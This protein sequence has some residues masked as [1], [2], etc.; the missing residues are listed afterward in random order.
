MRNSFYLML[1]VFL[2][3][4]IALPA[5]TEAGENGEPVVT[6][7][8]I[9]DLSGAS[10]ANFTLNGGYTFPEAHEDMFDGLSA[11]TLK[12]E[13]GAVALYEGNQKRGELGSSITISPEARANLM[14]VNQRQYHGSM[15]IQANS[16][17]SLSFYNDVYLE[18]Y[19][20]GVVPFE[21]PAGWHEEALKAQSIAARTYVATHN[22]SV[23]DTVS[24]QVY[25]G[26][27][28]TRLPGKINEVV[29][30]TAGE[31]LTYNGNLAQ[32]FYSSSNGGHTESNTGAWG[33][34]QI[35]YLQAVEDPYDPQIAWGTSFQAKQ[36]NLDQVDRFDPD[37][38]WND[39]EED[40]PALS[41]RIASYM[42]NQPTVPSQSDIKVVSVNDLGFSPERTDG[43]RV[44]NSYMSVDY[45]EKAADGYVLNSDGSIRVQT[46]ETS[47]I[48]GSAMR[49]M[50]G[51]SDMRTLL[52]DSVTAPSSV[53]TTRV[54]GENRIQTAV[55][56]SKNLYPDGFPV[57]HEKKT[58]FVST[59]AEFA[60][61]LSAG[62]LAKQEGN[63][64]ILLNSSDRLR[65]E[66]KKEIE[67][68]GAERIVILGGEQAIS[69]EVAAEMGGLQ[70]NPSVDRI[71]GENRYV[72]NQLINSE[73]ESVNG[74][75]VASGSDF[76]DAL[77][78][79]PVASINN[80]AI[81]LTSSGTLR[82]E[83]QI[84]IEQTSQL[85][86]KLLGGSSAIS[87]N[88]FNEVKG[89]NSSA[90]R[91]GG[92]N[93]YETLA[94]VL[95]EFKDDFN[96]EEL[97]VSTGRNFPD[98]LT[99]ATLSGK[100][101]A[102]L[103][104]TGST[105]HDST[106]DFTGNLEDVSQLTVLGGTAAVP[107]TITDEIEEILGARITSITLTGYGFGHGVGMSQYG[108]RER[109]NAGH[110]YNQIIA[111]Y[112]QGTQLTDLY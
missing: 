105:L 38:W 86:L 98:A 18:D 9:R 75:F 107:E 58:V 63:A 66:V 100:T 10:Q 99:A 65:T 93:R 96:Q 112:Y 21:M 34:P 47:Q 67:R 64:P 15:T 44:V 2:L 56:V 70:G 91:L 23:V 97:L 22:Y 90:E 73:L 79:A 81:V 60:D 68:L 78:S 8:L 33:S 17:G 109:A 28:P 45:I 27:D 13:S 71:A 11:F 50:I 26:Y 108:A 77:G 82:G 80:W 35:P 25:G 42:K 69:E 102:P 101:G 61:A 5:Q 104:L 24:H 7:E 54:S 37:A 14:G 110:T 19:V 43:G 111:F 6:V 20:K 51:L 57:N 72:T 29:N 59:S 30:A 46:F 55:K 52:V 39:I 74:V 87:E 106:K 1:V 12:A 62:P 49:T 95:N 84:Q 85:P 94:L 76:A 40:N 88:V 92:E 41:N 16:N 89:I 36:L 83:T 53:E 3:G 32:T 31:V 103:V 4:S 48:A